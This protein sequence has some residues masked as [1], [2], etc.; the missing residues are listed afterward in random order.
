M[1]IGKHDL[2]G[3]EVLTEHDLPLNELHE[4]IA[5]ASLP[6]EA[7]F[8]RHLA[9]TSPTTSYTAEGLWSSFVGW[10][11][12]FEPGAN[13]IKSQTDLTVKLG[14]LGPRRRVARKERCGSPGD[15]RGGE[16]ENTQ[17]ENLVLRPGCTVPAFWHSIDGETW[18]DAVEPP[19]RSTISKRRRTSSSST[20]FQPQSERCFCALSR[21]ATYRAKKCHR[22]ECV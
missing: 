3:R 16:Q 11:E 6:Q 18:T 4:R 14:V 13:Y 15:R 20:C 10:R 17:S 19:V 5:E 12:N 21:R 7:R 1:S 9:T 8:L 2:Q 22:G